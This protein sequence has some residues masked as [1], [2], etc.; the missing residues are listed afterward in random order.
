MH[1]LSHFVKILKQQN[2]AKQN[3]INM[4]GSLCKLALRNAERQLSD[5]RISPLELLICFNI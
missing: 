1:R 4:R 3:E 2:K 5:K